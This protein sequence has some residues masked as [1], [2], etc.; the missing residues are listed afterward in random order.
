VR[1]LEEAVTL[2]V[3][4]ARDALISARLAIDAAREGIE[5]ATE[6]YTERRSLAAA[7]ESTTTD[8]LAAET[9]LRRAQLQLVN[10]HLDVRLAQARL[11]RAI[12]RLAPRG[13]DASK[14]E[15]P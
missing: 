10:A 9:A 14:D 4:A 5:A 15:L 8:V 13:D 7:G 11:D 3:S 1:A 12:G 2:E 6:A